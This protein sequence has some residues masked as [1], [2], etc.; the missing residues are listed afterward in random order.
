MSANNEVGDSE[1][2]GRALSPGIG[3]GAALSLIRLEY[4]IWGLV[5]F[6]VA[7]GA[8]LVAQ[9]KLF[10]GT[11]ME[12]RT[13]SD[14]DYT[15]SQ[16]MAPFIAPG[17]T[18][19]ASFA[20][21][22][23]SIDPVIAAALV[24]VAM[25]ATT[26]WSFLRIGRQQQTVGRRRAQAALEKAPFE[27]ATTTRIEAVGTATGHQVVRGLREVGAVDGIQV[28]MWR[29]AE[30]TGIGVGRVHAACSELEK[31]GLVRLS[32]IDSG[33]EKPR[34]LA[35]LTPV[36]VRTVTEARSR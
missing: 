12:A 18:M 7:V 35:E 24:F 36:G 31:L 2:L 30:V 33:S 32:T 1:A 27:E 21:E 20:L 16:M 29:L 5:V 10:R 19:I 22:P 34:N 4:P 28:R 13:L 15:K 23:A 11:G 25:S 8:L 14:T 17:V 26:T 3:F 9:P 6:A